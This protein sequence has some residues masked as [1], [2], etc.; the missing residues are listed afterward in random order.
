MLA[1]RIILFCGAI[2][3]GLS[4]WAVSTTSTP[5]LVL[6]VQT[7]I[8][9]AIQTY[10]EQ[11][12]AAA[13]SKHAQAVILTIDT[14][15]GLSASM[16]GIV[17]AMLKSP[18]PVFSY[19]APS[20]GRAA[21]AGTFLVYASAF[22]AMAPG[23]TLGAATPVSI[24]G[25]ASKPAANPSKAAAKDPKKSPAEA[26]A[27]NVSKNVSKDAST[28]T[29]LKTEKSLKD[30]AGTDDSPAAVGEVTAM[31]QKVTNDSVAFIRSLAQMHRRNLD[32]A[33]R[34]VTEAATLTASEALQQGV[35]NAV[36]QDIPSLLQQANRQH[37]LVAGKQQQFHLQHYHLLHYQPSWKIKFLSVITAPSVA[38][39]LLM[40][41]IYGLFLEFAHP[42]AV[43]PGVL[44]AISLVLGLYALQLFPI[45]YAG[46]GLLVIG[47]GFMI[48]EAVMPSFGMLG[49]GGVIAFAMGSMMLIN[50]QHPSY[51]VAKTMII[52][53]SILSA[54]VFIGIGR[55]AMRSRQRPLVSGVSPLLGQQAVLQAGTGNHFYVH[56]QSERWR[57]HCDQPL[58]AGQTVK[59]VAV[60]G[61]S[62]KV[63]PVAVAVD[64]TD[65]DDA[66]K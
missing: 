6:R 15:G 30:I 40:A 22:A 11:G 55:L 35:V 54:A 23:T 57:V 52:L 63:R 60:N 1:K 43:A 66:S 8:G 7:G 33:Q 26:S 38:Y 17:K 39:F 65:H 42:G 20:G 5:V 28:A 27:K 32:F 9:P 37:M 44:G 12:L 47:V 62:L 3:V 49:I 2:L 21:S 18:V 31:R 19:V 14:P 61:V 45:N 41:G 29:P 56:L 46:L 4:A 59:V 51:Q 10:V 36:A 48:G 58:R 13:Q 64:D 24:G 50:T 34:A 16:R 25:G 53:F